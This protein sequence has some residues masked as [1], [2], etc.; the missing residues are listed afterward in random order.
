MK[1]LLF[2]SLLLN[3]G[4][5]AVLGFVAKPK[6]AGGHFDQS[7]I[8]EANKIKARRPSN[9]VQTTT[10]N[11]EAE[12]FNWRLV[13]SA[14]YKEYI[15]NLRKIQCPEDSIRDIIVADVNKI[16]AEKL[17]P[18]RKPVEE[19]KFWRNNRDWGSWRESEEYNV[20]QGKL[21]KEKRALLKELLGDDYERK[22]GEREY[23]FIEGDA[24]SKS[25]SE[26]TKDQISAL[27]ARIDEKQNDIYRKAKGFLSK[28]EE[29]EVVQLEKE[30][31][32]A[33]AKILSPEELFEWDLRNSQTAQN[34]K[35]G[36][37]EAFNASE[38][39]F[40]KIFKVKAAL[41][42]FAAENRGNEGKAA[43]DEQSRREQEAE[44]Q[45]KEALGGERYQE[46]KL[47]QD[48]EY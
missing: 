45:L 6:L 2:L 10:V 24:L 34:M 39:E 22:M 42:D 8:P 7:A 3:A 12:R 40:R 20:A 41:D 47:A 26:E 16:Y 14:N 5:M 9:K 35:F 43:Q 30:R 31:R 4:L 29:A 36:E 37:L 11:V 13:E 46:Y 32:A 21:E 1:K 38:G 33:M 23:W 18:L 19:W 15:S 48:S 44:A 17:K 27:Q 28:E 25:V